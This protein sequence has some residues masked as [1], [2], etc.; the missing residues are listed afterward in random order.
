MIHRLSSRPNTRASLCLSPCDTLPAA[1]LWMTFHPREYPLLCYNHAPLSFLAAPSSFLS[2]VPL[3]NVYFVM[4][5]TFFL[6]SSP[7][8]ILSV[9]LWKC[10]ANISSHWLHTTFSHVL[11]AQSLA[12]HRLQFTSSTLSLRPTSAH[13]CRSLYPSIFLHHLFFRVPFVFSY[14]SV[15]NH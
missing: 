3:C 13:L 10:H 4:S 2:E 6:V 9:V 7:S 1:T 14:P 15:T 12:V 11:F 5:A 8:V